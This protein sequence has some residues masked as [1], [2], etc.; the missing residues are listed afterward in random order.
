M[1]ATSVIPCVGLC[2]CCAG[3]LCRHLCRSQA[4]QALARPQSPGGDCGAGEAAAALHPQHRRLGA[5]SRA[6]HLALSEE[7]H[8]YSISCCLPSAVIL[9]SQMGKFSFR[10]VCSEPLKISN[11]R[12]MQTCSFLQHRC[13]VQN[14]S[15]DWLHMRQVRRWRCMGAYG[16]WCARSAAT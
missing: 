3:F 8:R 10:K 14:P 6:V 13:D 2:G 16:R 7:P 12:V 4:G 15:W 11:E 9:C 1:R 5:G